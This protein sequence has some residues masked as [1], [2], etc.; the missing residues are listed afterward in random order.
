MLTPLDCHGTSP[1][2]MVCA[3]L[4]FNAFCFKT[5]IT[6]PSYAKTAVASAVGL[7]SYEMV[8]ILMPRRTFDLYDIAAS[9]VG[10]LFSV[11]LAGVLFFMQRRDSATT[12]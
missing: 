6:L 7:S 2:F 1:N 8:Q 12:E 5:V 11:L 3:G 9:F 4:P 10:A